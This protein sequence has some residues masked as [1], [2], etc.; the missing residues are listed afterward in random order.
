V[1]SSLETRFWSKVDKNGPTPEH[2]PDL[3]PC[4]IWTGG[5]SNG[6]GRIWRDGRVTPA[7]RVA[8]EMLVG[9]LADDREPDH[10]CRNHPCVNPTHLEAVT[11]RENLRR[12][13]GHGAETHCPKGHP[14][15]GDNLM[16]ERG[17]N[18]STTRRCKTCNREKVRRYTAEKKAKGCAAPVYEVD[19]NAQP[20]PAAA[21]AAS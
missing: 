15:S 7:H 19:L 18:G 13:V 2:R 9:P 14:Y 5:T 21:E 20:I 6:Y 1:T 11:R 4:W 12:G 8:Y 10:L 3:G 17:K 16:L